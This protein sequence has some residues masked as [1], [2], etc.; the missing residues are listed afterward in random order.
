MYWY[1]KISTDTGNPELVEKDKA[2]NSGEVNLDQKEHQGNIKR[3]ENKQN[4]DPQDATMTNEQ[5]IQNPEASDKVPPKPKKII[6]PIEEYK[7]K[8][9]LNDL[10][11]T[12]VI[13]ASCFND[14]KY[15]SVLTPESFERCTIQTILTKSQLNSEDKEILN[16]NEQ[17]KL[18]PAGEWTQDQTLQLLDSISKHGEDWDLVSKDFE[19]VK[20]KQQIISYFIT[21]PINENTSEKIHNINA[22]AMKAKQERQNLVAEQSSVPTVFSDV[23]NPIQAQV[24]LFGRLLEHYGL[25]EED[26]REETEKDSTLISGLRSQ[27]K[28]EGDE[29]T[30]VAIKMPIPEEEILSKEV[31]EKIKKKSM[32]KSKKLAKRERK[33][34]KKLIAMI[35]EIELKKI[36]SKVEYLDKLDEV[37]SK[38]KEQV[39]EIHSQIFAQRISLALSRNDRKN[40]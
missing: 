38:E 22:F 11:F 34:L 27:T 13:C 30:K 2:D 17:E 5:A 26:R 39:K 7:M 19:G 10:Q 14:K 8:K 40:E 12:Y 33:E 37:I 20:T 31:C 6:E 25:D 23:S 28:Q 32:N 4:D 18:E 36:G 16:E 29:K 35:V 24:A 9:E 1:R 15:P 3:E 21:L